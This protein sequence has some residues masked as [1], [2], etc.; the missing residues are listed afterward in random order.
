MTGAVAAV[1]AAALPR[2]ANAAAA[3]FATPQAPV[4]MIFPYAGTVENVQGLES[5]GFAVL[6][7]GRSLSKARFPD[8]FDVI[9]SAWGGDGA[10]NFNVPD[11]RGLF[12][13]GVDFSPNS[14]APQR[15]NAR[16]QDP[17]PRKEL[18]PGGHRADSPQNIV[19]SYEDDLVG[20]HNH[21][22]Q[23]NTQVGA[24]TDGYAADRGLV[25]SSRGPIP[26]STNSGSE[27]RPVNAAVWYMIVSKHA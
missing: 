24:A 16:A 3:S 2:S 10:N 6:C 26:T 5:A 19:G 4:G 7:D 15:E 22:M 17:G 1:A 21:F 8:L 23:S 11:L 18:A 9:G 20:P 25:N 12:L 13:R 14:T 27:S